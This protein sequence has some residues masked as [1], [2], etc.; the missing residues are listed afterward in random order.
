MR[1]KVRAPP[2][3]TREGHP[4]ERTTLTNS[5]PRTPSHRARSGAPDGRRAGGGRARAAHKLLTALG[6]LLAVGLIGSALEG[7]GSSGKV[8]A[9]GGSATSSAASS[10]S[11]SAT[12]SRQAARTQLAAAH[13]A[14]RSS[15]AAKVAARRAANRAA[16]SRSA[17][18]KAAAEAAAQRAAAQRAARARAAASSRAAAASR[19]A[20]KAAQNCTPGYD[21]CIP[22]SSDVDCAGGSGNGPA[23]VEGPVYVT[24]SDPYGLDA[25]GDGVGCES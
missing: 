3:Q 19:A 10:S 9:S 7:C 5:V 23:Y 13:A 21:P 12:S 1:A 18:S 11:P 25:D 24:G 2:K 14:A 20:A 6:A 4:S 17:A 15:E 22:P 8:A 16:A